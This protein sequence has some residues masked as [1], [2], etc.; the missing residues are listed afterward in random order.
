MRDAGAF[1]RELVA[2]IHAARVLDQN[3]E[4][5]VGV[6]GLYRQGRL[7]EPAIESPCKLPSK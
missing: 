2:E 6:R 4:L 1:M 3:I 7:L 5:G